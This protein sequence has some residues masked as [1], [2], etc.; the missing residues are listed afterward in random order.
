MIKHKTQRGF[1]VITFYDDYQEECSIQKSS[2]AFDDYILV[3]NIKT[4][5]NNSIEIKRDA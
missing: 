3:N 5:I 4:Y 1:K 2:A